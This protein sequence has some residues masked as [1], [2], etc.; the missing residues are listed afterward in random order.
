MINLA[1]KYL[2]GELTSEEKER[3][4]VL[5][6]KDE[7][8]KNDLIKYHHLLAYISLLFRK[9]DNADTERRF[10]D[11]L[12]EIERKKRKEKDG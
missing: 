7:T 12:N 10:L 4:F 8:L 2:N 3:F 11:L 6:A 9:E 5:V 1:I